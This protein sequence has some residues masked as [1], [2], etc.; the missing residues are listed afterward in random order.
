MVRAASSRELKER[1]DALYASFNDAESAT[2]P[3]QIVRRYTDPADREVVGFCA[4]ALAFGRVASVLQSIERLMAVL[5]PS[6]A[7]FVRRFQPQR[8]G[9]EIK[10]LIHRWTRGEDL[11]ALLIILQQM[12]QS[13]SIERFFAAGLKPDDPDISGALESF[14]ERALAIDQ[15]EAYGD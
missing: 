6:P 9:R 10:P 5:G 15:R 4:A 8:D 12:L 1:L 2:D 7:A 11:I 14:S 13:G 3:I